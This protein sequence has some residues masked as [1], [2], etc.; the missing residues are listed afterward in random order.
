MK[1]IHLLSVFFCI[2]YTS[3]AQEHE[4]LLVIDPQGHSAAIRD[5]AFIDRGKTLISVSDDK[6]IRLWNIS[7]GA[8]K[9]TLRGQIGAGPLGKLYA[10]AVSSDEKYIAVAGN[11]PDNAIRVYHLPTTRLIATFTDH[12]NIIT[13]LSF[14]P[15]NRLLASSSGDKTIKI[16]DT[17]P[18]FNQD[19]AFTHI[20][21][22]IST[23]SGHHAEVYSV[24][25]SP[26]GN[27]LISASFDK[28]LILWHRSGNTFLLNK[29][30]KEHSDYVYT[31]AFSPD[32]KYI[33]S[34]GYDGKVVLWDT[35]GNL[36]N[37]IEKLA[38]RILSLSFSPEGTKLLAMTDIGKV[39][40]IP[41]GH[42]YAS[43]K[44]HDN[45]VSASAFMP[46]ASKNVA[47]VATAGGNNQVIFIWNAYTGQTLKKIV[48]KG[49]SAW[50]VAF[51]GNK[52][53]AIGYT[54]AS[55]K[56]ND[57]WRGDLE[58]SFDL[59][60]FHFSLQKP[61]EN[62]FNRTLS[63]FQNQPVIRKNAYTIQYGSAI[64]IENDHNKDKILRCYTYTQTG[65]M[66]VGS[67]GSLKLYDRQGRFLHSFV[68]HTGEIWSVSISA[69]NRLLASAS[70][71]QT[72]KIWNIA[73]AELL[74]TL[75]VSTDKEWVCWT[76]QG[77]YEASAGG[78]K[79]IGWHVNKGK[80]KTAEFFPS[81][82]FRK[83]FHQPDLVKATISLGTFKLA[84][85]QESITQQLPPEVSWYEPAVFETETKKSSIR[86]RAKVSSKSPIKQVKLLIDGR[87][88][89]G[90]RGL[91][92]AKTDTPTEKLVEY[93]IDL[94]NHKNSI[95]IF[96]ENEYAQ[97][98]SQ[99]KIVYYIA[100]H[101]TYDEAE[102]LDFDIDD[103]IAKPNL[104][105]LSV[106]ISDFANSSYN[107]D[108]ADDDAQSMSDLYR[109]Q[110]G[111]LFESTTITQ[112][113]DKQATKANIL[114]AFQQLEQQATKDDIVVIFMASHGINHQG[115][116][117]VLPH[118]GDVNRLKE[119]LISWENFANVLGNLPSKVIMYLDACHSGKLGDN[120]SKN[121]TEALRHMSS[122]RNGVVIMSAST[123]DESS[124]ENADWGHG[125]F[126][127][128]LLQGMNE[129]KAN[130]KADDLIYL[131]E[132][133]YY[134]YEKV[135][136]L[137]NNQQHP[138]T[139]KPS[140]I[141][142]LQMIKL[143]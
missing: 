54:P 75:F 56:K 103:F 127:Y 12:K 79:Y 11:L 44:L 119:T 24:D 13:G 133:D 16:W 137:T 51:S 34:G 98:V 46:L 129:G 74:A 140:T 115:D 107:L 10:L 121:N 9:K 124:L 82:V 77:Y 118:D 65:N 126:T 41:Y 3:F 28:H 35:N 18:I 45:T 27:K 109:R 7:S 99:E 71:D 57:A 19:S 143:E 95:R 14:S 105:M 36:H 67:A 136:E 6:T 68:G 2:A 128:A 32:G 59:K 135:V 83:H 90:K 116:F 96:A 132:L 131:R 48:G 37:I 134:V 47:P 72:V 15:D 138:T 60:N 33:A 81:H 114:Q 100:Q 62:A 23:L 78:E 123:G 86:V 93:E 80:N 112:L 61:D 43:F 31:A 4:P 85:Y 58:V 84:Q 94:V 29:K 142:S 64:Q 104:Y 101:N 120:V 111:L 87:P 69:D 92:L 40:D 106:G 130:I 117:Y 125:V 26:D 63:V 50:S 1:K 88:I 52:Q 42:Q 76:P 55:E 38:G 122:D 22:P 17:N 30:M 110:E 113:T 8:V 70:S 39:Y 21:T 97:A 141:S 108:F 49:R 139:Q 89:A 91:K 53:L 102:E 20:N 66:I 25:F 73:S 5:L